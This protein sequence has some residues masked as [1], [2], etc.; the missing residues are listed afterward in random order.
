MN[1]EGTYSVNA[2]RKAVWDT[3]LS[4]EALASAI[5]GVQELERLSEDEFEMGI[6]VGIGAIRGSYSGRVTITDKREPES[7]RML[8]Q[9]KGRGGTIRGEALIELV[10]KAGGTEIHVDGNARVTGLVARVGQRLLG[11]AS[12]TLMNQFFNRFTELVEEGRRPDP[13]PSG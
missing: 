7:L 13:A 4:P 3:L 8:V 11:S 9:G 5:P 2:D 6:T 10:E 1:V 12:K